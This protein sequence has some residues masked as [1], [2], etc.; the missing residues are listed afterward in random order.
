MNG[1]EK[2]ETAEGLGIFD[3]SLTDVNQSETRT[4]QPYLGSISK[5][6]M[7]L[8]TAE[9]SHENNTHEDLYAST[10]SSQSNLAN[11]STYNVCKDSYDAFLPSQAVIETRTP[12]LHALQE[13]EGRVVD[14]GDEEFVAW[15]VDITADMSHETEEAVIPLEELSDRDRE[16]LEVG[17]VFRWVIGYQHSIVGTRQR[18]SE[19]V[20]RDL[21][22]MTNGDLKH[23]KEWAQRVSKALNR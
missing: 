9:T 10:T 18:V 4:L 23:G 21:P 2:I 6:W 11:V 17:R 3:G 12:S 15:L 5:S 19:I 14:I 16:D 7:P 22:R 20:F 1:N 13:W 8:I